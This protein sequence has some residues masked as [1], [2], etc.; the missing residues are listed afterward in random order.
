MKANAKFEFECL[1]NYV[2]TKFFDKLPYN[3]RS[4]EAPFYLV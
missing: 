3:L 2:A 1:Q 4:V